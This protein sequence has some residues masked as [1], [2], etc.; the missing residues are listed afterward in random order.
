MVNKLPFSIIQGDRSS[1]SRKPNIYSFY[2]FVKHISSLFEESIF[3]F[4]RKYQC[5]IIFLIS[6]Y[7]FHQSY[8]FFEI[9]RFSNLFHNYIK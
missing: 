6:L 7:N 1:L 8:K 9:I 3:S 4:L 5:I 2:F